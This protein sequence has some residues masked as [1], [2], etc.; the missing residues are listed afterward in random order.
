MAPGTW[1]APGEN[2]TVAWASGVACCSRPKSA[3]TRSND[4]DSPDMPPGCTLERGE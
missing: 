3:V 2:Y 4:F 1:N